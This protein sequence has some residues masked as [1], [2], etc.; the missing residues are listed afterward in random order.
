MKRKVVFSIILVILIV[1][2]AACAPS[3]PDTSDDTAANTPAAVDDQTTD[4]AGDVATPDAVVDTAEPLLVGLSLNGMDEANIQI[5]DQIEAVVTAAGAEF[6]YTEAQNNVQT[7]LD[8]V[9]TLITKQCDVIIIKAIDTDALAPAVDACY[10]A[11]IPVVDMLGIASDKTSV[12]LNFD[13][14]PGGE[15]LAGYIS[16][17]LDANPDLV[18]NIGYIWGFKGAPP[19]QQRFDGVFNNL[20]E[21]MDAGRVN[22]LDEQEASFDTNLAMNV[23]EDWLQ[24]FADMNCII[25]TADNMAVGAVNVLLANNENMDDWY[26][27]GFDCRELADAIN[28]GSAEASVW[29]DMGKVGTILAE[30][31]LEVAGQG[32]MPQKVVDAGNMGVWAL[33]TKDNVQE[34]FGDALQQ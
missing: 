26:V 27:I 13:Q 30:N 23:T 28:D 7:Q 3:A 19:V 25:S 24:K 1:A 12:V 34:I 22:I 29:M 15:I 16:D 6:V 14:T 32:N 33:V 5:R 20:T 11:N 8:N 18:L 9:D 2:M 4:T 31:A 21:Y 17:L 10:A